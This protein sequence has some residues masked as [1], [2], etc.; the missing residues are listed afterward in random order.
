MVE[1]LTE[2][3][4]GKAAARSRCRAE[5][6]RGVTSS[7]FRSEAYLAEAQRLSHTGSFGWTLSTGDFHWSDE[8]FRILEYE[9]SVKPTM[10]RVLQRVHTDDLATV[11]QVID[12][13][14]R[15]GEVDITHR[16]LIPDG[17]VKFVHVLGHASKDAAGNLEIV[18]A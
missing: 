4:R 7:A 3:R 18:G 15:G 14:S 9:S 1:G 10:E 8:T 6:I 2:P 5:A 17:S 13:A 16:L 11:R 12:E